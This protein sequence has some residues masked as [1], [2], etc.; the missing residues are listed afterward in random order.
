MAASNYDAILTK[1]IGLGLKRL[2]TRAIMPQLVNTNI[3]ED[4]KVQHS[5]LD[6]DIP[7]ALTV[8][9]V[10]PSSTPRDAPGYTASIMSLALDYWKES[11]F[12]MTDKDIQMLEQGAGGNPAKLPKLAAGA[13]DALATSVNN[14]ILDSYKSVYNTVGA[15]GTTPFASTAGIAGQAM[16][17]IA[18]TGCTLD[19]LYMALEPFAY[20]NAVQ[21]GPFIDASASTDGN[22]VT[23][24]VVGRKLGF[25]WVQMTSMPTH[26]A[27]TGG[28]IT[29]NGAHAVT[30]VTTISVA[31]SAAGT[32]L[33]GDIITI[34]GDT[35]NYVVGAD[36]TWS[37]A[38][39]Q[40]VTISPGLQ[41]ALAGSDAITR[42]GN[43]T[44]NLAF[45]R[46]AIAFA[47]RPFDDPDADPSKIM[48]ITDTD[49]SGL[50]MRLEKERQHKQSVW[51]YDILA[52]VVTVRPECIVRVL[53]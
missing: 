10:T 34:A 36:V 15:A 8:A 45:H 17:Q 41:I 29:S 7:N 23:N 27:G 3:G 2:R 9:D 38:G 42:L 14:Y 4:P 52:G 5:T 22:V 20:A 13:I 26:V 18:S 47:S 6:I 48:M 50:A 39:N 44:V 1:M 28:T 37:G 25:G 31:N 33:E 32:L 11:A 30:G 21:L 24:G 40:N 46:D 53:G 16:A 43:H 35:Q 12:K 19:D 51:S 49:I